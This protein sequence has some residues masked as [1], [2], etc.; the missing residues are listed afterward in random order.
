M[1]LRSAQP[2]PMTGSGQPSFPVS[3]AVAVL[4]LFL[5][6]IVFAQNNSSSSGSGHS[7][8]AS[9]PSFSVS[10]PASH[11]Q[12]GP[13]TST[14]GPAH[15]GGVTHHPDPPHQPP[16]YW[17][18]GSSGVGGEVYAPYPVWYPAAVPY[19]DADS[20]DIPADNSADNSSADSEDDDADYQG[21]PTIFDRRGRGAESYIPPVDSSPA[22]DQSQESESDT[23][24]SLTA[25]APSDPTILVF[26][27]GHQLEVQNYAV[28]SQTLYDLTVGHR[29]KIALAELDL[30]ATE[31]LNEDRGI[32]FELPSAA[33]AN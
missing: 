14:A 16:H 21:G 32:I 33:Q 9:A 28:I 7:S 1:V 22:E 26:K 18:S 27:D 25:E 11:A 13:G 6:V 12:A 29:R 17:G 19:V 23:N 8:G 20:N 4:I 5:P 24:A 31:K 30:P 2:I 10:A 3:V 15:S